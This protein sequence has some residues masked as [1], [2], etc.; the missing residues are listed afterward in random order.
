MTTGSADTPQRFST[1][2]AG[3]DRLV[4]GGLMRG[5]VY[6]AEGPPGAGKTVL[7]NQMCFHSA[8]SGERALYVTLLSE[9]HDRMLNYL[10]RMR[11]FDPALIPEGVYF[12]SAFRALQEDGLAALLRVLRGAL[13]ERK[14]SLL[15]LDGVVTAEEVSL[16]RANVDASVLAQ[17]AGSSQQFKQFIHELQAVCS[18]TQCAVLLLSSTERP[19][20][21]HPAYTMVDGILELTNELSGLK[22]IRQIHVRKMRGTDQV[23][24]KH[25]FEITDEGVVVHPR[26]ETQL[27]APP[28]PESD[29]SGGDEERMAFGVSG[30]DAMLNGGLTRNSMTMLV[31]PTGAGKTILSLQYLCEGA[32]RGEKGLFFGFFERPA[33]LLLKARRLGLPLEQYIEQG[34][35]EVIWQRPIEAVIDAL[36]ERMFTAVRRLDATRLAIDSIQGFEL[37]LDDYPDR[38]R[39]VFAAIADELERLGV[40]AVYTLETREIFGPK[41]EVPIAGVSAATQNLILLRHVEMRSV[42]HLLIT[43]LKTRD[44]AHERAVRELVITDHGMRVHSTLA[45]EEAQAGPASASSPQQRTQR[46]RNQRNRKPSK[47]K[48]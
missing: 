17:D 41:I 8:R 23:L 10:Q 28:R 7:A 26:M 15:V 35:I 13:V 6:I 40:T 12:I 21:F 5:G 46:S 22:T 25:N 36:A 19:R 9:S 39:G 14:A 31:G 18:M 37:A 16:A 24:G 48:R 32:R 33:A 34:L 27:H 42:L 47:R 11:F 30:L 2:I 29:R 43:V 4:E 38:V 1:G 45:D 3:L 20:R 44:S